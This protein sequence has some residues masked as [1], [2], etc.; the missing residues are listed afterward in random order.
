[1][2]QHNIQNKRTNVPQPIPT[3]PLHIQQN[4][5]PINSLH[6]LQTLQSHLARRKHESNKNHRRQK[7][8]SQHLRQR[9]ISLRNTTISRQAT[10]IKI[11]SAGCPARR[12]RTALLKNFN[13]PCI[14]FEEIYFP[15]IIFV[16]Q[17]FKGKSILRIAK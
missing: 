10:Q 8:E 14:R 9:K 17:K 12:E 2:Q 4:Q 3:T 13:L 5:N 6:I 15:P 11:L 16:K 1:M 7:L